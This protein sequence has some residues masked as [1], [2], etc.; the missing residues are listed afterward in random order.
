MLG[1]G[2]GIIY[3]ITAPSLVRSVVEEKEKNLKNQMIVSGVKLP[4]YWAGHYVKDVIFGM[5]LGLWVIILIAIFDID[6]ADAWLLIILGVFAMPPFLYAF[7]FMFDKADNSGLIVTFYMFIFSF[8]GPIVIWV[9]QLIENTRDIG[10]TLKW[11]LSLICPQFAV[12]NGILHIAFRQF[13]GFLEPADGECGEAC[14]FSEPSSFDPRIARPQ[15]YMLLVSI[16]FWW[17]FVAF[18]DGS[19]WKHCLKVPISRSSLEFSGVDED[20]INEEKN[21]E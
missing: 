1:F 2:I 12:V 8:L 17:I 7:S 4:A 6:V 9:L 3:I 13:F 5:I 14:D 10:K 21:V 19:F 18:I 16:V 11:P 20:V 15:L